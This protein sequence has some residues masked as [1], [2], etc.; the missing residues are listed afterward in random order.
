[1]NGGYFTAEQVATGL[2][3]VAGEASGLSYEGFGGMVVITANGL[4]VRSLAEQP[5]NP[6]ETIAAA[7]QSFPLLVKPGNIAAYPEEDNLPPAAPSSPKIVKGVYYSSWPRRST[8]PST[9][10]ANG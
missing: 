6:T 8:S 3:I 5:Y 2:I 9:N 10:S 7:I 4:K 1:M